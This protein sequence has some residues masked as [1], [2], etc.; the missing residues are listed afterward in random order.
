M[1][2]ILHSLLSRKRVRAIGDL[3]QACCLSFERWSE[4]PYLAIMYL[5]RL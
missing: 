2:C 1:T 4:P 5:F 3:V